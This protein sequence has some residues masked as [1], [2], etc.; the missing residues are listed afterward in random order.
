[1]V[2]GVIP[3]R[4]G[5]TRLHA[6]PLADL[7]GMPLVVRV[8]RRAAGARRLDRLV[9]ATDDAR[10]ADAARA[11]GAEV[12]LTGDHPSGTDRVAE[13][14]R[15]LRADQVVNIQGDEPFLDPEDIDRVLGGLDPATPIATGSAPLEEGWDDPARVKVV[16]DDAGRAL[17]FSRQPIPSGGPYRLHVGLYAFTSDALSA[18]AALRPSSLEIA[19]RL[20][21]L[22][23][24]QAGMRVRV[25]PLGLPGLSIDTPDDLARARALIAAGRE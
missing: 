6:K 15:S 24:L 4:Y 2:L 20:E 22:R 8:W 12:F 1:M 14:A 5:S 23:W 11:H 16:C 25:V 19:E 3:A 17:Y 10:V 18:V 7:G 21:Q 9:V 13:V